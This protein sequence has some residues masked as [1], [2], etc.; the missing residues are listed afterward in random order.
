MMFT[1]KPLRALT[2]REAQARKRVVNLAHARNVKAARKVLARAI[3]AL[4]E[5]FN[6]RRL[7]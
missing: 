7:K 4:V 1:I 3:P 6:S 5:V 2:P